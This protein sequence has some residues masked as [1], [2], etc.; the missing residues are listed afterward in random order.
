MA[1]LVHALHLIRRE[2]RTEAPP[3]TTRFES[4]EPAYREVLTAIKELGGDPAIDELTE[5]IVDR[6]HETGRLPTPETVRERAR[7]I[8]D[9]RNLTI[10]PDSP[11]GE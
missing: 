11:I 5:W 6:I 2:R 3:P 1:S 4:Y 10:P 7:V 8:C 9:E